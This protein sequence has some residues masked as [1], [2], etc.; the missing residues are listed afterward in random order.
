MA[1]TPRFSPDGQ[2]VVLRLQQGGNAN[3]F[4]HRPPDPATT[5]LTD[6]AAI[7]TAPSYSPDGA[8][9]VFESDRGGSAAALRH[10][11]RRLG[12]AAHQ[13][14]PRALRHAGLVAARRPHRLHQAGGRQ[15]KIG[16][17]KPDGSGERILTEGFHNEGPTWAPNG[18]VMMFFRDSPAP[19]AARS[20][21]RSTSP[22][23][24]SSGCRRRR[25]ASDPA[26]S[27]LST[28]RRA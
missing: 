21:G 10:E 3:I 26:W 9:I 22:A 1:F 7:D 5:R 17:I 11:R 6:A 23:I 27:P 16:V 8:Q 13:L 24:T 15:F 4:D 28:D 2:Q 14:R 19:T 12:P 20:S 25:F 18:R